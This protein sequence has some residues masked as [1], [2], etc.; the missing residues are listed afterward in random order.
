MQKKVWKSSFAEATEDKKVGEAVFV[1]LAARYSCELQRSRR[2]GLSL[3]GLFHLPDSSNLFYR[4]LSGTALLNKDDLSADI[5][6]EIRLFRQFFQV[7]MG[8]DHI[9]GVS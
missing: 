7:L 8:G 4:P 1:V 9:S 6:L 3:K 5:L 2:F